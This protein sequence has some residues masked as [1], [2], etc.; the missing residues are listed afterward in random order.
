MASSS[1]L[2]SMSMPAGLETTEPALH[3]SCPACSIDVSEQVSHLFKRYEQLQDLIN[4]FMKRRTQGKASKRPQLKSQVRPAEGNA[5]GYYTG[6]QEGAGTTSLYRVEPKSVRKPLQQGSEQ[7]D[8]QI[9]VG[10]S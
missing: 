9:A 10:S 7:Q 3:A 2:L 6:F 5:G 4:S 1:T 8:M